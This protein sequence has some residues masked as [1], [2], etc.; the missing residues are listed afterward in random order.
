MT[1][2]KAQREL[3]LEE[4]LA[5]RRGTHFEA[6]MEDLTK[7]N[8]EGGAAEGGSLNQSIIHLLA[9]NVAEMRSLV[10]AIVEGETENE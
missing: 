1:T 3:L 5:E 8:R 4:V 10:S 9:M 6:V 7:L 2:T